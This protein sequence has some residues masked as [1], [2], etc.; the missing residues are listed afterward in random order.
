M[1]RL[2]RYTTK[3]F[4]FDWK[5]DVNSLVNRRIQTS[6]LL[7][8]TRGTLASG[9]PESHS[10]IFSCPSRTQANDDAFSAA[11]GLSNNAELGCYSPIANGSHYR[12]NWRVIGIP[13]QLNV[14]DDPGENLTYERVKIAGDANGT[15]YVNG[16][17]DGGTFRDIRPLGMEGTGRNYS[18]RMGITSLKKVNVATHNYNSRFHWRSYTVSWRRR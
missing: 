2:T 7:Y 15:G 13:H 6:D 12:V 8:G 1:V 11:H 3:A 4:A 14:R 10:D 5:R 16:I 9:D 18:R 17:D